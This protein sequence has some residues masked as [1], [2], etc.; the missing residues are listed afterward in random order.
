MSRLSC[1]EVEAQLD[2]YAAREC[3]APTGAAIAR[4]LA[5]C[6]GCSRAL[7]EA[8]ELSGLLD[9]H[10]GAPEGLRRLRA[11]VEA[12]PRPLPARRRVL[13]FWPRVASVAA[14]LLLTV[15]PLRWV[16][17]GLAPGP[18]LPQ[19]LAVAVLP[20]P[21]RGGLEHV[22]AMKLPGSGTAKPLVY[23]LSRAPQSKGPLPLPPTVNLS[24][25]LR[26]DGPRAVEVWLG[27]P[28]FELR[29]DLR[30]PGVV[31]A[32]APDQTHRPVPTARKV[33]LAPGKDETVPVTHLVSVQNGEVRYL[34]WTEPGVYT[35][36]VRV[37]A[38]VA[39]AE[40]GPGF[41]TLT[42]APVK[43]EVRREP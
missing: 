37:R 7:E 2:L 29:L 33:T 23:P 14:M 26:N 16:G 17:S 8:R 39:G 5:G 31:S 24:V 10:L 22:A 4:H 18:L 27:G 30:G 34:Y 42:S 15:G 6:P 12:E 9:L 40:G 38:P 28:R 19:G 35:L 11:R 20:A 41:L 36:T 3:D 21:S 13:A 25:Q 32:L 1:P 43:I